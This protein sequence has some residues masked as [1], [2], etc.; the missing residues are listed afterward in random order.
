[1]NTA[2]QQVE[3][4]QD[5]DLPWLERK[6]CQ[7]NEGLDLEETD[8]FQCK[9]DRPTGIEAQECMPEIGEFVR[10]GRHIQLGLQICALGRIARSREQALDDLTIGLP[11]RF[12]TL[13][14]KR[15]LGECPQLVAEG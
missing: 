14:L 4:L 15:A 7:P 1:M 12:A 8:R 5:P 6:T 3:I 9:P 10:H 2:K 13:Q 11:I